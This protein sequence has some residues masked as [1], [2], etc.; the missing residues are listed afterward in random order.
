MRLGL[1][2]DRCADVAG[3]DFLALGALHVQDGGLQ[4]P[5]ERGGLFGL[6]FL[7]ALDAL[8]RVVEKRVEVAAQSRQID[9]AG[10]ENALAVRVVR[11]RVQQVLERDVGVPPRK[12]FAVR[13]RQDDFESGREHRYSSSSAARSG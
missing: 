4:R 7:A 12:C 6:A 8:D 3:L 2:Q 10:A 13:D 9:A 1:L 11:E 5:G